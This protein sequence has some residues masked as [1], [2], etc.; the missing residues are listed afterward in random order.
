MAVYTSGGSSVHYGFENTA[1]F[2][3]AASSINKTFGLNSSITNLSVNTNRMEFHLHGYIPIVAQTL[4]LT[5][6]HQQ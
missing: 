4:Y 1:T 5:V 6:H 3:T 2:G